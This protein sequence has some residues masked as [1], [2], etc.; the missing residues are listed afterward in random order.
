MSF[1]QVVKLSIWYCIIFYEN[2]KSSAHWFSNYN[3]N[4]CMQI[5]WYQ[6]HSKHILNGKM[7]SLLWHCAEV[8]KNINFRHFES[9]WHNVIKRSEITVTTISKT[10]RSFPIKNQCYS[11]IKLFKIE[12]YE[13]ILMKYYRRNIGQRGVNTINQNFQTLFDRFSRK[14]WLE[15][16]F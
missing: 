10:W 9:L 16:H 7:W 15:F 14:S 1:I 2:T 3:R 6:L 12:I 8:C 11:K 5:E 13:G 4:S